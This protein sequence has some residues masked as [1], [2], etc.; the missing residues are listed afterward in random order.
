[1]PDR[2]PDPKPT[3]SGEFRLLGEIEERDVVAEEQ[4]VAG[5]KVLAAVFAER[6]LDWIN[7][8]AAHVQLAPKDLVEQ[9]LAVYGLQNGLKKQPPG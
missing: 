5:S 9:A 6:W 7:A 2:M 4:T 3:T 8:L 1:M